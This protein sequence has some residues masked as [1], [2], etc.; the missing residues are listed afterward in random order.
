MFTNQVLAHSCHAQ[1]DLPALSKCPGTET[2]TYVFPWPTENQKHLPN[3]EL[4]C[5]QENKL[6]E[7]LRFQFWYLAT[8]PGDIGQTLFEVVLAFLQNANEEAEAPAQP[9]QKNRSSR[10]LHL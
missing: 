6:L 5:A 1:G 9:P 2:T 8:W 3:E 10:L 4:S 7:G